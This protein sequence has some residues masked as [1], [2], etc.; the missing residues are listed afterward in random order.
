MGVVTIRG[1]L[2]SGA[3]EIGR[4]VAEGLHADYVDREIIAKVAATLEAAEEEVSAKEM[5]P[6]SLLGR[7]AA[8]L[9]RGYAVGAGHGIE[10]YA[11]IYLPTRETSLDDGRY[12]AGLSSVIQELAAGGSIVIRGRGS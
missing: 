2:G 5:P 9:G 3:P 7:I 1:Q 10:S 12:L 8:A 11:A 4:L 6:G